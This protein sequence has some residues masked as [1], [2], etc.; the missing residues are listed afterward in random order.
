MKPKS[1]RKCI[2]EVV[3]VWSWMR[4]RYGWESGSVE[5]TAHSPQPCTC[6][7][8]LLEGQ[9]SAADSV[10]DSAAA[11]PTNYCSLSRDST[12]SFCAFLSVIDCALANTWPPHIIWITT[13]KNVIVTGERERDKRYKRDIKEMFLQIMLETWFWQQI[14]PQQFKTKGKTRVLCFLLWRKE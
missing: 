14:L 1:S 9:P 2:L 5:M 11:V 3:S 4:Q 6:S 7:K 8:M 12:K 10:L 13:T